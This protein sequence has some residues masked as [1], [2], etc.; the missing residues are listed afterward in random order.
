MLGYGNSGEEIDQ[1]AHLILPLW[2]I[3]TMLE[4]AAEFSYILEWD[5]SVIRCVRVGPFGKAAA[6]VAKTNDFER[7][8]VNTR[9]SFLLYFA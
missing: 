9:G 3:N 6:I 5:I 4:C 8:N 2:E 1:D 7:V